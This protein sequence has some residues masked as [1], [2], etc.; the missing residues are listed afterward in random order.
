VA[1][2]LVHGDQQWPEID[3]RIGLLVEKYIPESDRLGF[4]F[5]ATDVYHGSRYFDRRKSRWN[6]EEK[7]I[8]ILI[9]LA[10]II[11]DL[12]LPVV[13]G[14]YKKEKWGA[15]LEEEL[16]TMSAELKGKLIHNAAAADCLLRA[17]RWLEKYAP[18]EL[19]T[20]VHEDGTSAKQIIKRAMRFLRSAERLEASGVDIEFRQR[21][22]LPLKR[23]IDT[24]HF[25][26]KSDARPL[27]LADLCAFI[28][29]R[30]LKGQPVPEQVTKILWRHTRWIFELNPSAAVSSEHSQ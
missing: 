21:F 23:I 9:D 7:R 2:I 30:G 25:A 1:G 14:N 10:E 20:V 4:V 15:G 24:V 29:A 27:Q 3:R 18:S 12:H 17:D 11:N 19:A 16:P 5:H 22:K 6:S 13:T 8:P 26:E 28:Y